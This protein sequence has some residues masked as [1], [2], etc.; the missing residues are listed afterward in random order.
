VTRHA[1][2]A[3]VAIL[4][5]TTAL[6]ALAATI[7]PSSAQVSGQ[8]AELGGSGGSLSDLYW[9]GVPAGTET[10]T[11]DWIGAGFKDLADAHKMDGQTTSQTR[12]AVLRLAN[13]SRMSPALKA[14]GLKAA[15]AMQAEVE[16]GAKSATFLE[17]ASKVLDVIELVSTTSKAGGYAVEGDFTGATSILVKEISKKLME[18]AGMAGLSW[19]PGGQMIGAL[20]GEKAF[21]S[22]VEPIIDANE[23]A[24]RDQAYADKYLN[25]PWMP[26]NEI[27]DS[28]G[29]VRMLD[30]DMYV[31]KGSGLIRRRSPQD[32][33]AYENQQH[34]KWLDGQQWSKIMKDLADGKIDQT[35][36]DAL[37]AAYRDRDVTKPWD[38]N[39]PVLLGAARFAGAYAGRFS[40]G[41]FGSVHFT[42]AGSSVS[43]TISGVCTTPPCEGDPVSGSF[44]GGISDDGVI[45]TALTGQFNIESKLIGPLGFSGSFNGA[46]LGRDAQGEWTG[47]NRYGSPAGSWT[48]SR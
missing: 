25:K 35:R 22:Q 8:T 38:P 14:E 16:G 47:K 17:K 26:K 18:G 41:G 19:L 21:E 43:G 48:A 3:R 4:A 40:G 20:A 46:V 9:K 13:N 2:A 1:H 10:A 37:L 28:T 29:T 34:T 33:Q 36:Y 15:D 23:K 39:A 31:E 5:S 30:P 6:F 12:K 7:A 44:H 24:V 32:Q 11:H 42:V 27:I 45:T